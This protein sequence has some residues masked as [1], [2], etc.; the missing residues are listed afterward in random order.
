MNG[1]SGLSMGS[2]PQPNRIDRTATKLIDHKDEDGDGLLNAV[3]F[4][5]PRNS[6]TGW[7]PMVTV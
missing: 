6:L 5:G 4:G 1:L 2:V 3:E 7:M